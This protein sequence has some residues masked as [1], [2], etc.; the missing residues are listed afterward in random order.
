MTLSALILIPFVGGLLCWQSERL[1]TG[2][3]RWIALFCMS[4]VLAIS[5]QLWLTGNYSGDT[6]SV[7]LHWQVE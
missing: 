5:I 3:P 4:L 2:I 7:G 1:G 6:P